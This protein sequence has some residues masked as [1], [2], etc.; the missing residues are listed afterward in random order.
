MMVSGQ[1]RQIWVG[2]DWDGFYL[3]S[4]LCAVPIIICF[5]SDL[6]GNDKWKVIECE[7]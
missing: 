1:Y 3:F 5:A 2:L 7:A 4:T 6:S